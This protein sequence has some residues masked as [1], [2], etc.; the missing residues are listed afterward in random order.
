MRYS[1]PA[2]MRFYHRFHVVRVTEY[3]YKVLQDPIR[4]IIVQICAE[5]GAHIVQGVRGQ[6]HVHMFLSIP[7]KLALSNVMQR[8]KGRS[9][10]QIQM[11]FPELRKRYRVRCFW[12]RGYFS[13]TSGHVTDDI[14]KQ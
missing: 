12:A 3:R 1:S 8:I 6:D 2:H 4:E 9:P 11:E 5:M 10:R 7:P 13:T 14:I